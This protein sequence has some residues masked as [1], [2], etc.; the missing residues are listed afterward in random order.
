MP[1]LLFSS[2]PLG[3]SAFDTVI[4]SASPL[5]R[6]ISVE[7]VTA[8]LDRLP[9]PPGVIKENAAIDV[10]QSDSGEGVGPFG[11]MYS[12]DPSALEAHGFSLTDPLSSHLFGLSS[13]GTIQT[14]LL[15]AYRLEG[16][17]AATP[18][19]FLQQSRVV[20]RLSME[21]LYVKHS[22][23]E[24]GFLKLDCEG[25]DL[26]IL[27]SYLRLLEKFLLPAPCVI[28]VEVL[29][30]VGDDFLSTVRDLEEKGYRVM[31]VARPRDEA[32]AGDFLA[33]H[34]QC[35]AETRKH[36]KNLLPR[37]LEAVEGLC[38]GGEG[39]CCV[40]EHDA[41]E[42]AENQIE[43]CDELQPFFVEQ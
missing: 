1:S 8:Y 6:G 26:L 37:K 10:K 5:H 13:L 11:V 20:P 16:K 21:E 36:L 31:S 28:A 15:N 23:R 19:I 14:N 38:G 27:A 43:L 33:V 7:P 4:Q 12:Q 29:C 9:S 40:T 3:T 25:L 35:S 30:V 39:Y 42:G 41:A 22:V 34:S 18:S 24:V 17:Y 2:C 32:V